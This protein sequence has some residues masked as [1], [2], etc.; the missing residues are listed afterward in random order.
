M[1]TKEEGGAGLRRVEDINRT[2][3]AKLGW[4]T[5]SCEEESGCKVLRCKC[6]VAETIPLCIMNK[7]RESQVWKGI[8]WGYELLQRGLKWKLGNGHRTCFWL[9]SWID[10][11]PLSAHSRRALTEE[12]K[13][14]C[15]ADYW[16]R[17]VGWNWELVGDNLL[18]STILKL[19][20]TIISRN[21]EEIDG[22][23]WIM[24]TRCS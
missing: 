18:A 12:E 24:E 9:D 15:V 17:S 3:L 22:G 11:C 21:A 8:V 7:Q 10:E 5:I 16:K 1:Q 19:V 2:L 14:S 13:G 23:G 4:R 6:G 20:M